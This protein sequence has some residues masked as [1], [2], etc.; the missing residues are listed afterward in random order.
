MATLN[1]AERL[2]SWEQLSSQL[3]LRL[4]EVPH[5]ERQHT[6]LTS[7]TARIKTLQ[8]SRQRHK[9]AMA[10][11]QAELDLEIFHAGEVYSALAEALRASFGRRNKDLLTFG[12]RP[13]RASAK[14]REANIE[15]TSTNPPVPPAPPATT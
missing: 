1:V 2:R 12:L 5:L 10:Q 13:R 4:T 6:E 3:A 15:A 11:D 8:D 9:S 14:A 7:R